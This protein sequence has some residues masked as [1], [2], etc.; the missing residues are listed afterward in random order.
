MENAINR[1]LNRQILFKKVL[2]QFTDK[3]NIVFTF[4]KW[5]N[6]FFTSEKSCVTGEPSPADGNGYIK[7]GNLFDILTNPNKN[8][9]IIK[10]E[11]LKKDST[12]Y[13]S[14]KDKVTFVKTYACF[15][16]DWTTTSTTKYCSG[17]ENSN[18]EIK[19]T[20]LSKYAGT[21]EDDDESRGTIFSVVLNKNDE[22][23]SITG[24]GLP[25][26][27]SNLHLKR[28]QGN[29]FELDISGGIL[30]EIGA[31]KIVYDDDFNGF[32]FDFNIYKGTAKRIP[33]IKQTK[34]T[35]QK[36]L[37]NKPVVTKN[38]EYKL[39]QS[40][41]NFGEDKPIKVDNI[42]TTGCTSFPFKFGCVNTKI[43]DMNN[44]LLGDRIE[45]TYDSHL[46]QVLRDNAYFKDV[47]EKEGEISEK[48]YKK[49]M[50][51]KENITRKKVI[52]EIV[53]KVL[54]ESIIKKK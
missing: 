18:P 38:P 5:E 31:G 13:I 21:F 37:D 6:L 25:P 17:A 52:K 1:K 3:N 34:P 26:K 43:G 16:F 32:S 42:P 35:K 48:I 33:E 47:N 39:Y 24:I 51:I 11:Y 27:Y 14:L 15:D 4:E 12:D 19:E 54:K 40:H 30:G 53:K 20:E 10:N 29:T 23:L 22:K 41:I 2:S 44:A 7:Q 9:I 50:T 46:Y 8:G 28:L 36:K 45:N 49:V